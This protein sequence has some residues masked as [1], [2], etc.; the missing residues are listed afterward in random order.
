[1]EDGAYPAAFTG[2]KSFYLQEEK[3]LVYLVVQVNL[4]SNVATVVLGA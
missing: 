1:V 4:W 2:F 3:Q